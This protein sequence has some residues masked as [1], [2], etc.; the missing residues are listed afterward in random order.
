MW[1]MSMCCDSIISIFLVL[2]SGHLCNSQTRNRPITIHNCTQSGQL[3]VVH[4]ECSNSRSLIISG[5]AKLCGFQDEVNKKGSKICC[6]ST[7]IIKT[8]N[9]TAVALQK[10]KEYGK[11]RFVKKLMQPDLPGQ[12]DY[13]FDVPDCVNV[14]ELVVGGIPAQPKEYPHMALIGY[15]SDLKTVTWNCGGSLISE[16]FIMSAAHCVKTQLGPPRWVLLGELDISS[17]TEDAKPKIY[18]IVKVH[19]HPQYNSKSLYYDISLFQLNTTVELGPYVRPACLYTASTDSLIKFRASI[20]GWGRT[21]AAE[22]SSNSLQKATIGIVDH[23]NCTTS[24]EARPT[25]ERGYDSKSM[26]C[27][28]D[29]DK[30]IDT[31]PGDSGGPLQILIPNETCMWNIIGVTSFG[32]SICGNNEDSGVY[33]KVPYY[34]DW[35]QSI[36]WP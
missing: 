30:G 19:N 15:G 14:Q 22:R 6:N 12:E 21:G 17:T 7:N 9:S 1:R 28:G 26:I 27:A 16:N 20:T 2:L 18:S 34:L 23:Q 11:Y 32:P 4:S 24:F 29:I 33:T 35:I 31:C 13:Y 8:R 10:C 25:L 3:C 36:V 5:R